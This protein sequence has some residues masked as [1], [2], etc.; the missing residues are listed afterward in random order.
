MTFSSF[1]LCGFAA[2]REIN[3]NLPRARTHVDMA[4]AKPRS[5]EE[6]SLR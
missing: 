4:H 2:T 6:G 3:F 5:R 1:L